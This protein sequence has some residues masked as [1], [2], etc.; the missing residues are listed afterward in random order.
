MVSEG[1]THRSDEIRI[2]LILS[3][4]PPEARQFGR[5]P[6]VPLLSCGRIRKR[7]GSRLRRASPWYF[8]TGERK[9]IAGGNEARPLA[10]TAA[11]WAAHRPTAEQVSIVVASKGKPPTAD[12]HDAV[13]ERSGPET[14]DQNTQGHHRDDPVTVGS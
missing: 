13:R 3:H 6:N 14:W 9:D 10:S 8:T 4:L 12:V 2:G 7:G 11:C 5:P 1:L